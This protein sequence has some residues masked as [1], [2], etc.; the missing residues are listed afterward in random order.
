MCLIIVHVYVNNTALSTTT[1]GIKLT[2][3]T[4]ECPSIVSVFVVNLDI[5]PA[6]FCHCGVVAQGNNTCSAGSQSN[7]C[8][9]CTQEHCE[10][11][12]HRK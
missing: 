3:M 1:T 12:G 8:V 11:I 10:D 5:T 6:I 7:Q 9:H 2:S 4:V